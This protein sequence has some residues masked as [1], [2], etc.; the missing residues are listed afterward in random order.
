MDR[1]S[2]FDIRKKT[3]KRKKFVSTSEPEQYKVVWTHGV[4]DEGIFTEEYTERKWIGQR[5][6]LT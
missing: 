4:Y 6:R 1:I 3:W 5:E 2:N